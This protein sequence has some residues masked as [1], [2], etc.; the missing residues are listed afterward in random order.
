[1][2]DLECLRDAATELFGP[3]A[4]GFEELARSGFPPEEVRRLSDDSIHP[5]GRHQ[6]NLEGNHG[7]VA[8]SPER[9]ALDPQGVE[10]DERFLCRALVKIYRLLID[11]FGG[12]VPRPIG[13][14]DAMPIEGRNLA[15]ERV[16]AS[17]PPAMEDNEHVRATDLATVVRVSI[18]DA[19]WRATG[20]EWRTW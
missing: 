19:H 10:H 8:V 4:H 13:H 9:G 15:V 16:D 6:R 11:R 2:I 17:A 14:D 5:I 7:A 1:M 12:A 20:G 18:T 3:V